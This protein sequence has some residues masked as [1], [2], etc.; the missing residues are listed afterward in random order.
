VIRAFALFCGLGRAAEGTAVLQEAA[1]VV[2]GAEGRALLTAADALLAFLGG[3][4]QRA[5]RRGASVL[6]D[7]E[8]GGAARA[9][10]AAAVAAGSAMTGQTAQALV[11]VRAGWAAMEAAPEAGELILVRLV[12]TQAE[13]LALLLSGRIREL[14][15]Q[16]AEWHRRNLDVPEWAGDA[17]A[18]L[19]R[20][21]AALAAGRPA[22][23][24]RW[25]TEALA[26]FDRADP[27]GSG[28]LCAALLATA[29]AMVGDTTGSAELLASPARTHHPAITIFGPFADLARVW[30]AA[31]ERRTL[32]A[33]RLALKAAAFAADRG[34]CG[35]EVLLLHAALRFGC[36]AD[37]VDR[38]HELA[39]KLD[40]PF[41]AQV[42]MQATA[43]VTQSGALLDEVSSSF[44]EVG[45]LLWAVDTAAQA[46]AV[47]HRRGE[48]REAALAT[49][50][51]VA[52][53]REAG[54][55]HTPA[56]GV[57]APLLTTRE[58]EVAELASRGF[59]NLAIAERLVVSVRTVEAHLAHV[60]TKLG[61]SGRA[62]LTMA[63]RP[64]ARTG[65][66]RAVFG[67]ACT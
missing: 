59:S 41:I 16:A 20:G 44:E 39:E 63:L 37:V 52:L 25:F 31:A 43:T 4:P 22:V 36:A 30:L 66:N 64:G 54:L 14:E 40:C 6:D 29:R 13:I 46:A 53:A 60:Y 24:V 48:R 26:G 33:G 28:P 55:A 7:P 65:S 45:A 18:G 32:E 38:L 19:G 57:V 62:E 8:Q 47:H 9:L 42:S 27:T 50:T 21:W 2:Q 34:Q 23:A 56:L 51:A 17:V 3:D 67:G 58:E 10:A 12:L 15:Q 49:A 5:V 1:V 35:M 11:A 61:I